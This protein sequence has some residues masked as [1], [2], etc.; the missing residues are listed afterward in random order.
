MMIKMYGE[1]RDV[2]DRRRCGEGMDRNCHS[3]HQSHECGDNER[4]DNKH[5]MGFIGLRT[6]VLELISEEPR[7]GSEIMD[8]MSRRTMSR[9]RPS[10]GSVY[11]L[12][13]QLVDDG[14]IEKMDNGKYKLTEE[15][16]MEISDRRVIMRGFSKPDTVEEMI[17]EIDAFLDYIIDTADN[18]NIDKSRI[19]Q[20]KDKIERLIEIRDEKD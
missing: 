12:L 10:P 11:P 5:T 15:G 6:F 14:I 17:A 7:K 9:W 2:E 18:I 8:E 20:L 1:F 4:C 13:S 16:K 19:M 3:R